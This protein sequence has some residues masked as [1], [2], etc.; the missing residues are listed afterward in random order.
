MKLEE[1]E[2]KLCTIR[3]EEEVTYKMLREKGLSREAVHNIHEGR[4]YNVSSLFKY[5]DCLMYVIEINGVLVGNIVSLGQ[6]LQCTRRA[7]GYSLVRVQNELAWEAKQVLAIEKGRGYTRSSLLKYT[8][9]IG[10]DY[11]LIS[12]FE[13]SPEI[14]NILFDNINT[15]K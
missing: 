8:S 6:V 9:L 15:D 5:L 2:K 3:K 13:L 10:A 11:E 4:E 14:R 7:F 1:V 12:V